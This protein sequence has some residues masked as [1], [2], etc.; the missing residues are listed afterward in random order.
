[1]SRPLAVASLLF[2]CACGPTASGV[3]GSGGGAG[4]ETE[5]A[6]AADEVRLGASCWSARGTRWQVTAEGPGGT[7]RFELDLLA[8]GRVRSSDHGDASPAS[9]EWFQDGSLLRV[10]LGDRFV[11]YR[12]EVTNGTVLVGEAINVRGQRWTFRA[13]RM[14]GRAAC[15]DGEAS[16]EEACLSVAGTRWRL[17]LE[18]QGERVI[19][20]L[21]GGRVA[22]GPEDEDG[23]G[24]WEQTGTALGFTLAEDGPRLTAEIDGGGALE[25]QTEDGGV[26]FRATRVDSVPPL[27]HR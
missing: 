20:F 22:V 4:G 18:G 26:R 13:D 21:D 15:A 25:G 19:V 1:M 27:I 8:A 17:A 12:A 10:F 9:D 6:C 14:F 24:R 16:L 5:S 23:A 3:S 2:A 11:E 7:Y